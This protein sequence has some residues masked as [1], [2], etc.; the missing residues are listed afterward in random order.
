MSKPTG[1]Q[2]V[3]VSMRKPTGVQ[4]VKVDWDAECEKD[5]ISGKGFEVTE[6]AF[7]GKEEKSY[8][9]IHS[10][11]FSSDWTDEDAFAERYKCKCGDLK[12]R[13]YENE[14]CHRCNTKVTFKDVDM[15]ITGWI[16]L[17]HHA[18]MHPIF[19]KMVKSIIG[20]KVFMEI[21]EFDKEI[22]R[23]G[24]AIN[25]VGKNPFK[26]IGL[27][28]FEERFDE[29]LNYYKAKKKNKIDLVN[30]VMAERHKVFT[31]SI[32]VY[33]SILR[34]VSFKGESYFYNL[35]DRKYNAIFS[36]SR[37]LNTKGPV[38]NVNGKKVKTRKMD[39]PTMLQSLQKK[40]MELWQLIFLQINQKNGHIKDQLL[41]GRLN[42]SSRNVIIPDPT[43]RSNEIRLGY[44]AFLE[45]FKYEIIAHIAKMNDITENDAYEQWFKATI[46]YSKKIYE[47]M[48]Y[49]VKK[50]KIK[51]LLNR[52]P[53]IN[54]GSI[55]LMKIKDIKNEYED[56]YTMS[57]PVQILTVSNADLVK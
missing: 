12:G 3:N 38:P 35:I 44:L 41:G 40:V 36:L 10:S 6:K 53:T 1:L 45:L 25:K 16:K 57:I 26:G 29:I 27:I 5:F 46:N 15:T 21:I 9:G 31:F 56:D 28:E 11:R 23:D 50:Q 48:M 49:L 13:V 30:E 37:S 42:F 55:L 33:S 51:V 32:P 20:D 43:L 39:E 22:N 24:V 52:N 4:L 19:Y 14:L 17:K 7:V 47:V 18:I 54:Y 8:N 34:P 2:L